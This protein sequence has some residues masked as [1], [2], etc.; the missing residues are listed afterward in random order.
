MS[1]DWFLHNP[2]RAHA[3]KIS[4]NLAILWKPNPII[5]FLS[6]QFSSQTSGVATT[7]L[8]LTDEQ[9][10]ASKEGRIQMRLLTKAGLGL[11][12]LLVA[13]AVAPV[14]K[15]DPIVVST[16][17]FSL[18]NLGNNGGGVSG[19]DSLTGAAASSTHNFSA[20]G[21][22]VALLNPLTFTTGFTG[23]GSSGTYSFNFSQ[24]LT[25]NGV[26]QTLNL[27]GSIT[28]SPTVDTVR[29]LSSAPLTFNFNTFSV[30]V[31]VLPA[32]I[33]EWGEGVFCD[34]LKAKFTVTTDCNPVPEPTTLS[35][36][37]LGL[38]G[39]AAKL[40]RRRRSSKV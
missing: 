12:I 15:A 11:A 20:P 32:T 14:A 17:G 23:P 31:K 6:L 2:N 10:L 26:T 13:I 38:A 29:I 36:L 16:G 1:T 22:F 3:E 40:R 9:P 25:I 7:G 37:G 18:T 5:G 30:D 39:V 27:V 33:G 35:L 4:R 28:I 21:S 19:K 24:P 34:V 8:L